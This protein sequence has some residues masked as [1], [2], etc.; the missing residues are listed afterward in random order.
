MHAPTELRQT[1]LLLLKEDMIITPGGGIWGRTDEVD[2]DRPKSCPQRSLH[3]FE[4]A[5]QELRL[6][7]DA[8]REIIESIIRQIK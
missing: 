6:S 4:A 1:L 3:G 5:D 8:I 7:A 2:V